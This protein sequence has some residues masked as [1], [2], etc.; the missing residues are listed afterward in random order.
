M[1]AVWMIRSGRGSEH[2]EAFL[3]HGIVAIGWPA[4][5][6]LSPTTKK[7]EQ[8]N[9]YDE[10]RAAIAFVRHREGDAESITPNLYTGKGRYRPPTKPSTD[11]PPVTDSKNTTPEV[12][13]VTPE[14]V[15]AAVAA[16]KGGSGSKDPFIS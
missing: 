6:A 10:T 12:R 15:A 8:V 11:I 4:L 2:V 9:L 3:E 5:G 1:S 7:D 14:A 16:Q 13:A